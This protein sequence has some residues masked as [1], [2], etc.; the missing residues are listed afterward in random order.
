MFSSFRAQT[1]ADAPCSRLSAVNT[2]TGCDRRWRRSPIGPR[3]GPN[4]ACTA[5]IWRRPAR[6][7]FF[8][9]LFPGNSH[10]QPFP[11]NSIKGVGRC[12]FQA[13][14]KYTT[15]HIRKPSQNKSN[16]KYLSKTSSGSDLTGF[17]SVPQP[18]GGSH[19]V[20]ITI[21]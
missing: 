1:D 10:P 4:A 21:P 6:V 20:N 15:G 2:D 7:F 12:S 3:G 8:T 11:D 17:A 13:Y 16:V 14:R 19:A 5:C 18:E 9:E